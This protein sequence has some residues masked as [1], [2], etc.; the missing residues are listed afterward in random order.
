MNERLHG[1]VVISFAAA[2]VVEDAQGELTRCT[3][4]RSVGR[5][6][7]GDQVAWRRSSDHDGVVEEILPRRNLLARPN[8]RGDLKG[9]AANVDT[10]VI[11]AAVRPPLELELIDRYLVLAASLDV[12]PLILLNKIDLAEPTQRTQLLSTLSEFEALGYPVLPVSTANGEG[13]EAL[14]EELARGSNILVGQSGVGKSS[15]V[16]H[17][18]PDLEVRIGALSHAS[19]LGRH[20]TT[21]TT[22]YPLPCGGALIDSPGIRA[23]RL[24]HLSAEEITHGFSELAQ[25]VGRCRFRDCSHRSEPG[26]ALRGLAESGK[27]TVRR[28]ESFLRILA[29]EGGV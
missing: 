11:V 25:H 4:R 18:L 27:M 3:S 6:L 5:P 14:R 17:L 24:G 26:C 22:L 15:L 10:M 28:L 9:F 19:G 21:E 16:Q 20:T 7:C 23:L 12:R 13:M 29:A 2:C 8:Y 1:R